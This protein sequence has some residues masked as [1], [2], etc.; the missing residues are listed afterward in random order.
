MRYLLPIAAAVALSTISFHCGKKVMKTEPAP[1]YAGEMKEQEPPATI[2][3]DQDLPTE[4]VEPER[5][6]IRLAV[7]YG[8]D[9]DAMLPDSK[10][11]LEGYM[12]DMAGRTVR[13]TGGACPIGEEDYNYFL[14]M[15]RAE[16]AKNFLV[17]H[18]R[19]AP[20]SIS[21]QSVGEQNL[22]SDNPKQYN[23]NRRCEITIE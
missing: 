10:M 18:A 17:A 14:G 5:G 2:V 11:L 3:Y 22:I 15:R 12:P 6:P 23:L 8:F 21:I 4:N 20:A 7:L 16:S 9:S 13:L 19:P 1:I